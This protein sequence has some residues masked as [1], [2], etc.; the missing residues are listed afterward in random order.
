MPPMELWQ[1]ASVSV[2]QRALKHKKFPLD[3]QNFLRLQPF[4][5][6]LPCWT[7]ISPTREKTIWQGARGRSLPE[8][9]EN[10]G[11]SVPQRAL[12]HKK[13]P[14][15]FQN[16]LRPQLFPPRLP[17]RIATLFH[18]EKGAL[19]KADKKSRQP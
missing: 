16:F 11:V 6:R 7:A 2:P 9:F 19:S 18:W 10:R 5:P 1:G 15:N 14:L 12:K 3:F 13:F 17:C 4:P 8:I